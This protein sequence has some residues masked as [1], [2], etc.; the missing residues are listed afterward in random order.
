MN[1]NTKTVLLILVLV[2]LCFL[3]CQRERYRK[4]KKN[5]LSR[6]AVKAS[7]F[8]AKQAIEITQ[9]NI[10][11]RE[12]N[13]KKARKR[14]EKL[15]KELNEANKTTSKVVPVKKHKGNFKFY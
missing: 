14:Q 1:L 13:E 6:H 11:N 12:S 2:P 5:R 15:Q 4:D 10:E 7:D 8:L 3:S 9:E